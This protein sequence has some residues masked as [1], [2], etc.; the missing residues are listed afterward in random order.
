[1]PGCLGGDGGLQRAD[2]I[3]SYRAAAVSGAGSGATRND[4]ALRPSPSEHAAVQRLNHT[5][6]SPCPPAASCNLAV[7]E[8]GGVCTD[9]R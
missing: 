5:R 6:A 2:R 4:D 8:F 3:A 1:V 7:S 9:G